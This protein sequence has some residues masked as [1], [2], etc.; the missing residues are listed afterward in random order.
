[1][2]CPFCEAVGRAWP[3]ESFDAHCGLC[4][5]PLRDVALSVEAAS[6]ASSAVRAAETL[7]LVPSGA[8]MAPEAPLTIRNVGPFDARVDAVDVEPAGLGR[9]VWEPRTLR[10]GSAA[11]ATLQIHASTVTT[12][13]D[14][15]L[16][17]RGDVERRTALRLRPAPPLLLSRAAAHEQ[18]GEPAVEP[19]DAM[20]DPTVHSGSAPPGGRAEWGPDG[21][22]RGTLIWTLPELT[23]L[24][25][26]D[27]TA[28]FEV[29]AAP[30]RGWPGGTM[31]PVLA[32]SV[33]W[34]SGDGGGGNRDGFGAEQEHP[35]GDG[36]G[37]GAGPA[38]F[39]IRAGGLREETVGRVVFQ[40]AA[41]GAPTVEVPVRLRPGRP[42]WTR[43]GGA[44]QDGTGALSLPAGYPSGIV[45]TFS[46]SAN[47]AASD[48]ALGARIR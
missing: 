40:L 22:G 30:A 16:V 9:V 19:A 2:K 28:R 26:S 44:A 6:E 21:S 48:P 34:E 36:G 14:V 31:P 17:A 1:M 13:V 46:P 8:G 47:A 23:L 12:T 39:V 41:V 42:E 3:V 18:W 43:D 45:V 20:A 4:G 38:R 15:T 5:S 35:A 7:W 11:A 10:P 32:G 29:L 25:W 33:K 27:G 37:G 24:P